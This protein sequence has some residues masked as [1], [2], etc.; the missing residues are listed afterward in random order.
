MSK[1]MT[2]SEALEELEQIIQE[3]EN[4]EIGIDD[5]SLKVKRASLLL[6][7]CKEKLRTT[8]VDINA[9]LEEMDPE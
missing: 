9:I 6:K 1:K 8:E 3:I 7:F 4:K 5:L 2:Y